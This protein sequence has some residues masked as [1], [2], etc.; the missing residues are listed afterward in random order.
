VS[1]TE[2]SSV[3]NIMLVVE[4]P[5]HIIFGVITTDELDIYT[6]YNKNNHEVAVSKFYYSDED[7]PAKERMKKQRVIELLIRKVDND[8]SIWRNHK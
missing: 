5:D 8:Y 6:A 2:N 1:N 4:I 7:F 3:N